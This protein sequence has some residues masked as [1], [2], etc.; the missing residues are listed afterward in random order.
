MNL[1]MLRQAKLISEN[2]PMSAM[3]E[4]FRKQGNDANMHS[5]F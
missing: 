3:L 5:S 1:K 2:A 4:Y